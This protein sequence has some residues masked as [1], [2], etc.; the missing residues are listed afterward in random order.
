LREIECDERRLFC[1]AKSAPNAR[2]HDPSITG[3]K[4]EEQEVQAFLQPRYSKEVSAAG[5]HPA[6]RKNVKGQRVGPRDL[7]LLDSCP[8]V[9]AARLAGQIPLVIVPKRCILE[10]TMLA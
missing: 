4:L 2:F 8:R 5:R 9:A 7:E 1:R 6:A 10:I 3:A